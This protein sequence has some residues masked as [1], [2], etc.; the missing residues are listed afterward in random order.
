MSKKAIQTIVSLSQN[1]KP[2]PLSQKPQVKYSYYRVKD[3]ITK[4]NEIKK[5]NNFKETNELPEDYLD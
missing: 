1:F 2:W 3:L 5:S 4:L